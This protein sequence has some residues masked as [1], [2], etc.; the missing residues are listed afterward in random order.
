MN[1]RIII[2]LLRI[3][4][5]VLFIFS[6]ISKLVAPGLFEI[7][8]LNQGI[9]ETRV[10]AAYL[11]RLL[12]A[13]ELFLGVAL[14]QPYYLKRIILPTALLTLLG[15]TILLF[16]VHF[17]G[18]SSN[19]GCFGEIIKMSPLEAIVKNIVLLFIGVYVF[20]QSS[21]KTKKI[22][23]PTIILFI[24]I[25]T[26]FIVAPLKSYEDL[27][28]SKYTNFQNEGM[29]DLTSGDKL[30]AV[31]FIDCEHCMEVA[32]E[33]VMLEKETSKLHNFYILFSGEE[34][35]SVEHFLVQTNINHPY[36]KIP[37]EDF[38]DL[39]GNAPPR[40]YWLQDGL[41]KEYWDEEFLEKIKYF[42]DETS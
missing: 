32:N 29:V 35:D 20:L 13:L 6:A 22:H 33:I 36:E 25:G 2:I 37:I 17:A 23:F 30:V 14:L 40:I 12:I 27:I 1:T 38:F 18:D 15:F 39:I 8:I 31:F 4:L 7:T 10:M 5:S 21:Y 19:C 28:F 9:I 34:T 16:F 41:V 26:V 42:L 24:S 3:L 11:G